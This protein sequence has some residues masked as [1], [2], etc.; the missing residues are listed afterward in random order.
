M[1]RGQLKEKK[2]CNLV[3]ADPVGKDFLG[4]NIYFGKGR[5][6]EDILNKENRFSVDVQEPEVFNKGE[7]VLY[8]KSGIRS[9]QKWEDATVIEVYEADDVCS[10]PYYSISLE[11]NG[12]EIK[13]TPQRLRK[14]WKT[15]P[16]DALDFW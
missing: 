6:A 10:H 2:K 8:S 12:Q 1:S 3:I 11:S 5:N 15:Y 16:P 7:K 4:R 9:K 13:T 14:R